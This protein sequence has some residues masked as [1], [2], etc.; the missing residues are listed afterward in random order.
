M[1]VFDSSAILALLRNEAGSVVVLENLDRG[2]ISAVNLGEIAQVLIRDGQSLTE[3]EEIFNQL[4]I[5]VINVDTQMA[6]AAAELRALALTK[7]LS[8]ADCLCLALAKRE[9]EAA[10]TADRQWLEVADAIGVQVRL[11]R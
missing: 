11:I 1:V 8:Q 2:C 9:G 3:A 4:G 7:G 10:L 5:P 6:L